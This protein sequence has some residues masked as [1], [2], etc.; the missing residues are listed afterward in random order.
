MEVL[1]VW[2]H[3]RKEINKK[4][5][6]PIFGAILL[7][8]LILILALLIFNWSSLFVSQLSP[9]VNCEGVNFRSEFFNS[10]PNY[11]LD[12]ENIGITKIRGL[13]IRINSGGESTTLEDI[14]HT[15]NPGR[16]E[17]IS[18]NN[19]GPQ[20]TGSGFL[21][22]PKIEIETDKEITIATCT[23]NYAEEIKLE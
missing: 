15:I 11:F 10:G 23:N 18:L 1:R 13:I 4:A 16:T 9:I 5:L 7:V 17:R 21:I 14:E 22:I 2:T 19:V 3:N 20:Q 8:S 12:V 6:S